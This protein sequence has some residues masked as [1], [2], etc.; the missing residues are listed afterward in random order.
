[1]SKNIWIPAK[2]AIV[3][4]KSDGKE[5]SEVDTSIAFEEKPIGVDRPGFGKSA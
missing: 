5:I 3:V 4:V 2:A 1:M